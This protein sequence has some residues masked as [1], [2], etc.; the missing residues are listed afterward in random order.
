MNDPPHAMTLVSNSRVT[1]RG[2]VYGRTDAGL[3]QAE[4]REVKEGDVQHECQ[5]EESLRPSEHPACSSLKDVCHM[6]MLS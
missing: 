3:G 1:I 4:G 2:R 6:F 5:H